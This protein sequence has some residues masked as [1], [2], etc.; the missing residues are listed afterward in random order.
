M[1]I[2]ALLMRDWILELRNKQ[3]DAKVLADDVLMMAKGRMMLRQYTKAL[4]YTHQ[5]LQDMG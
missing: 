4:D 3:V 2:V 1:T 5:Y